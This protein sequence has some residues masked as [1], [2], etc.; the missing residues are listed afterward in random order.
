MYN[1]HIL[2]DL[3][4]A[5]ICYFAVGSII[6]GIILIISVNRWVLGLSVLIVG[7]SIILFIS[8]GILNEPNSMAVR[9]ETID[10][11]GYTG[12][13]FDIVLMSDLHVGRFNN[14]I[15][16][17]NAIDKISSLEQI[18]LVLILGDMVNI[19]SDSFQDLDPL[20][21][22]SDQTGV[23]AVYGN[24]DYTKN[25]KSKGK[26]KYVPGLTEKLKT[27]GVSILENESERVTL[28]NSEEIL[29]GG[30]PDIWAND[31][32]FSFAEDIS[33]EETFL[34]LI[35]N[36]DGVMN[37]SEEMEESKVVDLI[38]SGHTHGG[39][40]RLPLIGPI[41]Q[42]PIELPRSYDQGIFEYEDIP[43]FITSGIGSIGARLRIMNPPEIVVLTII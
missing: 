34:M 4:I 37:V 38:L 20:M 24:H 16:L 17:E 41:A 29:I 39:E 40:I 42:L 18:E 7:I 19:S 11:E 22:I 9:E 35:H 13:P 31:Y 36:P 5:G 6:S 2:I 3:I 26:K 12:A 15:R 14:S 30:I 33:S 25:T 27:L 10:L 32:D 43:L 1:V 23:Y 8:Y 21:D 28:S